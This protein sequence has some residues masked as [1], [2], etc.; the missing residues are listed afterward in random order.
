MPLFTIVFCFNHSVEILFF[1]L[2]RGDLTGGL[3]ENCYH[4]PHR[5]GERFCTVPAEPGTS[6]DSMLRCA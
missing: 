1:L 2:Y 3:E 4:V 6:A 5:N